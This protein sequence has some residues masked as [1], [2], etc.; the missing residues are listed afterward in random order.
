MSGVVRKGDLCSGHSCY[1]PRPS[2]KGSDT[3]FINDKATH[4]QG[5]KWAIHACPNTSPHDGTLIQGSRSVFVDGKA[6][7]RV[8]DPISC[9]SKAAE[10]SQNVFAG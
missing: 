5:D 8:K 3:V 6:I 10:G 2:I 9:G 1:P 4:R 7:A